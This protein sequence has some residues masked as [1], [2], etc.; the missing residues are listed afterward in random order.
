[1]ADWVLLGQEKVEESYDSVKA[2]AKKVTDEAAESF[3]QI[4]RAEAARRDRLEDIAEREREES[5]GL[6]RRAKDT[7]FPRKGFWERW[8]EERE[9][10]KEREERDLF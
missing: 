4:K 3:E 6:W 8:E 5:P 9:E 7:S 10:E 1:V 2:K